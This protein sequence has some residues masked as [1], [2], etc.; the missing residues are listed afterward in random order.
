M[1]SLVG[2]KQI[3][4][5]R[6]DGWLVL[7]V[8]SDHCEDLAESFA[9]R[10]KTTKMDISRIQ[11]K[12]RATTAYDLPK[13][14]RTKPHCIDA[15]SSTDTTTIRHCSGIPKR[16]FGSYDRKIFWRGSERAGSFTRRVEAV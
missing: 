11:T 8:F 1:V 3:G 6:M 14:K 12:R 5:D 15:A 4:K 7:S 10:E 16:R 9:F 13:R 2:E